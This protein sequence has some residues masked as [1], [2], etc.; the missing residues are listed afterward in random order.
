MKGGGGGFV[1]EN[2]EIR[3]QKKRGEEDLFVSGWG[4][5]DVFSRIHSQF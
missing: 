2:F 1:G 4:G 5:G 3:G